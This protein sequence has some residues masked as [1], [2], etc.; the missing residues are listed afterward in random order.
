MVFP[1]YFLQATYVK[2]ISRFC[3]FLLFFGTLISIFGVKLLY[4]LTDCTYAQTTGYYCLFFFG[5]VGFM[6]LQFLEI[7]FHVEI[8]AIEWH[9]FQHKTQFHGV[10][11]A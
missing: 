8:H 5:S 1:L 11:M 7:G 9:D 4:H 10:V 6:P 2:S 3:I